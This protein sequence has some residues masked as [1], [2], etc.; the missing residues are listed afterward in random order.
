[1]ARMRRNGETNGQTGALD[2]PPVDSRQAE[3]KRRGLWKRILFVLL[4]LGILVAALTGVKGLQ[5]RAMIAH[6]KNFV[7]PPETVTTA[8]AHAES[9]ETALTAVGSLVCSHTRVC[10]RPMW[11]VAFQCT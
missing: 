10:S 1:M 2:A 6:G 5:I 9:W 3:G 11:A 8:A 7:P 4:G